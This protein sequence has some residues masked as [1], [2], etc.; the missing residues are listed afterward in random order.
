MS[1]GYTLHWLPLF[2]TRRSYAW[3]QHPLCPC[4]Q[5]ADVHA[6]TSRGPFPL[7]FLLVGSFVCLYFGGR[8]SVNWVMLL[9]QSI[10][11]FFFYFMFLHYVLYTCVKDSTVSLCVCE[12]E[13]SLVCQKKREEYSLLNDYCGWL[14]K[15]ILWYFHLKSRKRRGKRKHKQYVLNTCIYTPSRILPP[16]KYQYQDFQN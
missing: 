5:V 12:D 2:I 15:I 4:R 1:S 10:Y 3:S 7:N 9:C 16:S 14:K 8:S 11:I 13:C 6:W